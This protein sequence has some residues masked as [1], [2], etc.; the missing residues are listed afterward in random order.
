M[1]TVH[2]SRMALAAL[3][4][5]AAIFFAC[6]ISPARAQTPTPTPTPTPTTSSSSSSSE[7]DSGT[8]SSESVSSLSSPPSPKHK[9]GH[10]KTYKLSI[11]SSDVSST[12][13][14]TSTVDEL[15]VINVAKIFAKPVSDVSADSVYSSDAVEH[16]ESS[17][18][19]LIVDKT[20][21]R[22]EYVVGHSHHV[23]HSLMSEITEQFDAFDTIP[24]SDLRSSNAL[25]N[26]ENFHDD[27]DSDL[28]TGPRFAF[29]N[30][31]CILPNGTAFP[32]PNVPCSRVHNH[33]NL[34][35]PLCARE[36]QPK[37]T[38]TCYCRAGFNTLTFTE[39]AII[40]CTRRY[41]PAPARSTHLKTSGPILGVA[42]VAVPLVLV[43]VAYELSVTRLFYGFD[44]N[45]KAFFNLIP[46]V[47]WGAGV[48]SV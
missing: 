2:R 40:N 20:Q 27:H 13:D 35:E 30:V 8:S 47:N 7:T 36:W 11:G 45:I 19:H 15:P 10:Q 33:P 21:F 48:Q 34:C 29:Q 3:L 6:A 18:A 14:D 37:C 31:Q 42:F 28:V 12:T 26:D 17:T 5:I 44:P 23:P 1:A 9:H 22:H 24:A 41:F 46:G 4:V 39:A 43:L 25:I 32:I 38:P 16:N